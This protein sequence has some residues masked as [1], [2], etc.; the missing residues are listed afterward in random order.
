[1][2]NTIEKILTSKPGSITFVLGF[3]FLIIFGTVFITKL[4]VEQDGIKKSLE[5]IED[6]MD[7]KF[8]QID[9]KFEKI[10]QKFEKIDQKFEKID[11]DIV[12]LKTN[13]AYIK[14]ILD[15]HFNNKDAATQKKSPLALTDLGKKIVKTNN[16]KEIVDNNWTKIN[17]HLKSTNLTHSFDIERFCI[18]RTFAT[19]EKFF[20]EKDIEKLNSVAYK[21]DYHFIQVTRIMSA[22]II[23][24][25]FAENDIKTSF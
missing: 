6:K 5:R 9:Q 3:M 24:R 13:L 2:F 18:E 1:M 14:G 11:N 7:K 25:Y 12:E 17:D 16:L 10:D 15:S 19:P 4:S 22:L 23:E 8:E 21:I 20:S